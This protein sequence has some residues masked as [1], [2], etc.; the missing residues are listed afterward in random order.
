[1][2]FVPA[3]SRIPSLSP[4]LHPAQQQQD[5]QILPKK[6]RYQPCCLMDFPAP[7]SHINDIS[8][9]RT[10]ISEDFKRT[11]GVLGLHKLRINLKL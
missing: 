10:S 11:V 1:M 5:S 6:Q 7:D 3:F 2:P 4:Q 8:D 9:S